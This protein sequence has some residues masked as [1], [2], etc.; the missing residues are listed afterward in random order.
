VL[1]LAVRATVL[2]GAAFLVVAGLR[3]ASA[4]AR[5]L[6][7][8][9]ALGGLVILPAVARII[10]TW[11]LSVSMPAWVVARVDRA[12]ASSHD[13]PAPSTGHRHRRRSSVPVVASVRAPTTADV[14]QPFRVSAAMVLWGLWAL[15][16][17]LVLMRLLVGLVRVRG[18]VARA[19]LE[20]DPTWTGLVELVA[21]RVG[22]RRPIELR[23]GGRGVIPITAGV[24]R[25]VI[26]VPADADAWDEERRRL[27]LTHEIGHV[28]RLDV[29]THMVGQVAVGLFWF[30]PLAWIAAARMRLER[31]RACDDVVLSA[32][33]RPSRYAGDLLELAQTL[34]CG[35]VPAAAALAM[36]MAR[37]SEI[38]RRLLAILDGAASRGPVGPRR[39]VSALAVAM[40]VV[41]ALGVV[42]PV[43]ASSI[44]SDRHEGHRGPSSDVHVSE[45]SGA[46]RDAMFRAVTRLPSVAD[47]RRAL[48]AILGRGTRDNATVAAVVAAAAAMQ[49]DSDKTVVL[50]AV[51][52]VDHLY[53]P[54]VRG[55]FFR[56]VPTIGCR[57]SRTAVLLAVLDEIRA[58]GRA[59]GAVDDTI[60]GLAT[61]S[62][63][64]ILPRKDRARVLREGDRL[65]AGPP[66]AR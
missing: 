34:G 33:A 48:L 4:A 36:A 58:R 59:G 21:R 23:R 27:V 17:V 6:V 2:L 49:S 8:A 32:G 20:V 26:V 35:A 61:A 62:A 52:G 55:A 63:A 25:P 5:H 13:T 29:L 30:H 57:D 42:R 14:P 9:I 38:E 66:Q 7:W 18:V 10:P 28:R 50:R 54:A 43:D 1:D 41:V 64:K 3:R 11:A 40:A 53:D 65:F 15:G 45:L 44:R 47:R 39:I 56:A 24:L 60:A 31:E 12:S 51:A 16:A 46:A 37:P 19:S 22:V